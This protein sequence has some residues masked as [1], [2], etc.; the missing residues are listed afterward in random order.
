M[1]TY[2]FVGDTLPPT[3]LTVPEN[4]KLQISKTSS[5]LT[6]YHSCL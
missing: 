2:L 6:L 4:L 1:Q 3:T 5:K